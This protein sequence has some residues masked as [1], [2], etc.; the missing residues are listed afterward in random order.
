MLIGKNWFYSN[1]IKRLIPAEKSL[2][3]DINPR[4]LSAKER[5]T[6]FKEKQSF[7]KRILKQTPLIIMRKI[8]I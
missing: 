2:Q 7:L 8:T 6:R 4:F 5:L 1:V 3:S